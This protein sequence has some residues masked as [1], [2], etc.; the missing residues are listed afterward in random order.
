[1]HPASD[2]TYASFLVEGFARVLGVDAIR[3]STKGFPPGYGGGR[4]LACYRSDAPDARAF[5]VFT[6]QTTV[7]SPGETWADVYAM[8]NVAPDAT[9]AIM[10]L[11]PT[12][13]IRLSS[14]A[15]TRR[16]L[17][18]TWRW[19]MSDGGGSPRM[20]ARAAIAADRS[21]SLVKH[22]RRRASIDAYTPRPS[23]ADYVFFTAWPWAKHGAVNPPRIRFIEACM[24][25]SGLTFEG[26]F[27]PRRRSDVTD[28]LPY[29]AASRYSLT[30]YLDNLGRSA[31]AFNN[32]AVHGCLGWKLG[33]FLAMGKAIISLPI[34]RGLPAPLEHGLHLHV[35]DGSPESLDDAIGRLRVDDAYRHSLEVNAR[36]WY[37]EQLAPQQVASRILA[38]LERV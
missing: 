19:A 17:A 16:H 15:L 37:D 26:G 30:D 4:V 35:V 12:F 34:E 23:E 2:L 9:E 32:P 25:A 10:P 38:Q 8:V 3:Y 24:R 6:D 7:N 36:R 27:A 29:T 22:Q 28:V 33:E 21:R 18:Q 14:N 5:M 1:M 13:G 31:V 20:R 11:G